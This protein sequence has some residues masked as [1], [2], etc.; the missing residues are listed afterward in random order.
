MS[1]IGESTDVSTAPDYHELDRLLESQLVGEALS[2]NPELQS[3]VARFALMTIDGASPYANVARSLERKQ[4]EAYFG[5]DAEEMRKEYEP[6]EASSTFF[7][8]VDREKLQPTGVMRLIKSS[9][10]G[11]KSVNDIASSKSKTNE[12]ALATSLSPD[13][14]LSS[15]AIDPE[16]TL[17]I[18]TIASHPDYTEKATNS[19]IVLAALMGAL[20]G[21]CSRNNIKDL[22]AII[23]SKP[24]GQLQKIALPIKTLPNIATPFEYLGAM[25]NSF[26][27]IPVDEVDESVSSF[28]QPVFDYVFGSQ[29]LNGE[30]QLSFLEQ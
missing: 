26:I 23:D 25:G 9:S 1:L 27:H 28:S 8:M 4:F 11:F 22:V 24:L 19:P 10:V 14:V 6:Y 20:H 15:M 29:Q 7:L 16:A 17:D 2:Q 13:E 30:C 21:Y 12:G 3:S 5:N 18:A